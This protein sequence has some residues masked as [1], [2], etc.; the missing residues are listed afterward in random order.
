MKVITIPK[1]LIKNGD[2]VIVDKK[3]IDELTKEDNELR[4]AVK[5]VLAGELA[6]R[7]RKTRSVKEFL[8]Y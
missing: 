1:R 2:L 3:D 7:Q 4:L 5:A 6:L 8:Q